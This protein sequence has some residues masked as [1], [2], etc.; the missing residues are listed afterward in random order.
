MQS[1]ACRGDLSCK[2]CKVMCML[3]KLW[4]RVWQPGSHAERYM[5]EEI[6]NGTDTNV[7]PIW[8]TRVTGRSLIK[9]EISR[10]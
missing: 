8:E 4:I 7:V 9:E 2:F 1:L 3:V 10:A 5:D 6:V